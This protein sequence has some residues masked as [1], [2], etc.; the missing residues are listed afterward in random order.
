M[1]KNPGIS[2]GAGAF[3]G[4]SLQG[5]REENRTLLVDGKLYRVRVDDWGY[6]D[7]PDANHGAGI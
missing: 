7:P 2:P 5:W 1:S 6:P 4:E 3:Q